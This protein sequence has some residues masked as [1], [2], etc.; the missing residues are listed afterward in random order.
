MPDVFFSQGDDPMIRDG[1]R[2]IIRELVRFMEFI[3]E[4]T[5]KRHG[6]L[7]KGVKNVRIG[8]NGTKS[9]VLCG[10]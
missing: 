7:W 9:R 8:G 5:V 1:K 4:I 3:E 2:S 10:G 6:I